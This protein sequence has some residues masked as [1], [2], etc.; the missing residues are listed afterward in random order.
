MNKKT[1]KRKRN[2]KKRRTLKKL[3]CS[4]MVAKLKI[5][6]DTCITPEVAYHIKKEYNKHN[7]EN[8]IVSNVP[9]QILDDL[10]ERLPT[11]SS[12]DC[13][14]NQIIDTGLREQ[15]G[16]AI[17][18]PKK[19][20]SWKNNKNE[21]LSDADIF[22]V[23]HQYEETYPEFQFMD[24]NY[25]DFDSKLYGDT[26]VAEELCKFDLDK[27][28]GKTKFAFV[29]N[30][31]KHTML[32]SHWVSLYVDLENKLLFFMDS[33]GDPIPDEVMALVNRI[34]SQTKVRLKFDQSYPMEHQYGSSE[35]G[36]YSLY[37]IIT[38]LTGK[39]SSGTILDCNRNKIRYFKKRRVP[40]KHVEQLRYKYFN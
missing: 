11:C 6:N 40:D 7:L 34:K 2:R 33:A 3:N 27:Y 29:F 21:W 13:F 14:L 39:T 20:E 17:F 16:K 15:I 5:S 28:P 12:E 26:C 24:S 30:L 10:R 38:M 18:S 23:I 25:I 37:F 4:P 36:M 32:G 8:R 35:C 1:N 19:P 22:E 31:S 9:Y